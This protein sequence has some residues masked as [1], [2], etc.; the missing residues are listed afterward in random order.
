LVQIDR[1]MCPMK[2]AHTNVDNPWL[3]LLRRIVRS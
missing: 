1:L 2:I 3:E